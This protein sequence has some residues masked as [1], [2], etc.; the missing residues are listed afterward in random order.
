MS[1]WQPIETAPMHESILVAYDSGR[2]RLLEGY[3]NDYEWR[4]YAGSF[5][6]AE[7]CERLTHWMPL[8]EPPE[9]P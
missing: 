8:P 4:P 6:P 2:I 9:R 7:H 1:E 5:P 3:E